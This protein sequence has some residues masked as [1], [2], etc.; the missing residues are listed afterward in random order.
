MLSTQSSK[1]LNETVFMNV[2]VILKY[3]MQM[4]VIIILY[5]SELERKRY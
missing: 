4:Q 1:Y 3:T 5:F 2:L